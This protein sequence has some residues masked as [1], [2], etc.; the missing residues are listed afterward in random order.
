[1]SAPSDDTAEAQILALRAE[2]ERSREAQE[3]ADLMLREQAEE[4]SE[5]LQALHNKSDE[6]MLLRQQSLESETRERVAIADADSAELVRGIV[7]TVPDAILT[8]DGAGTISM[9]NPAAEE[10]FGYTAQELQGRNVSDL[11]PEPFRSEHDAYLERYQRTGEARI[12]G[13]GREVT[14]IRRDGREFPVEL[15][16]GRF[17]TGEKQMFAGV[18]RDISAR[19]AAQEKLAQTQQQLSQ[20]EKMASLGGLV[21]GIAHEINTP[22]GIGITA[23][24][25]LLD[26]GGRMREDLE[27]GQMR[28]SVLDN[29]LKAVTESGELILGNLERAAH[30]VQSFKQLAVVGTGGDRREFFLN[31]PIREILA[32]RQSALAAK[33]IVSKVDCDT[34]ITMLSYPAD[35]REVIA[36]LLDNALIH[37]FEN[38][39]T[40]TI[41]IEAAQNDSE[42]TLR[43]SDDGC[44]LP[45]GCEDKIFE[46]FFTTRRGKGGVGLGLHVVFNL[47]NA[48]LGGRISAG[49]GDSG[50]EFLITLP[51]EFEQQGS[52]ANYD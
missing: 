34:G 48:S 20:A 36:E 23:T 40:G 6:L 46:P 12:I 35:L 27:G 38:A 2:L 15:S 4:L 42:V 33:N 3:M 9:I 13:I 25:A 5:T 10:M 18:I 51:R 19:R 1:M 31:A 52:T 14:A 24:S 7:E 32:T 16:I 43:I 29:F 44:G 39:A 28:R 22:V 30:L 49:A 17:H 45:A 11:M 50:A 26:R 37:A 8:I 41:S 21:A 47:V